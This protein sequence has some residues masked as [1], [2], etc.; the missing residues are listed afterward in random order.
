LVITCTLVLCLR[1]SLQQ[2]KT[3]KLSDGCLDEKQLQRI[4]NLE[5]G[6]A[7]AIEQI[8]QLQS[9][10]Q[11]RASTATTAF[12]MS[13]VTSTSTVQDD[14]KEDLDAF[15]DA[16][17]KQAEAERR[18]QRYETEEEACRAVQEKAAATAAAK[19]AAATAAFHNFDANGNGV[20]DQHELQ[21]CLEELGFATR[22]IDPAVLRTYGSGGGL[23]SWPTFTLEQFV[24]L[25]DL[26][27]GTVALPAVPLVGNCERSPMQRL[28]MV[29]QG[30]AVVLG[31]GRYS[32]NKVNPATLPLVSHQRAD[33]K[34][35]PL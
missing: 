24:R 31:A 21:L 2:A 13:L 4:S 3:G 28:P 6:L 22:E 29:T 1:H 8:K 15:A 25:Y 7:D 12:H 14:P 33:A 19:V 23:S 32:R 9:S 5:A 30:A 18:Q 11:L 35:P 26:L 20:I 34:L 16:Q 27:V 17:T 10:C